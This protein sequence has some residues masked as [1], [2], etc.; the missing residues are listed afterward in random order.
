MHR[1]HIFLGFLLGLAAGVYYHYVN[2]D[3]PREHDS[4]YKLAARVQGKVVEAQDPNSEL[5]AKVSEAADKVKD[6]AGDARDKAKDSAQQVADKAKSKV[7]KAQAK[8]KDA[9]EKT[10]EDDAAAKVQQVA[11]S[12]AKHADEFAS[13]DSENHS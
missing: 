11:E 12:A 4:L 1:K 8:A 7:S 13:S 9:A 2:K 6:A 3:T 5:H 10:D